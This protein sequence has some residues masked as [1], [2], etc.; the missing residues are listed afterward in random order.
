MD[1]IVLK[2]LKYFLG[3]FMFIH[4]AG[5]MVALQAFLQRNNP[6]SMFNRPE[7]VQPGVPAILMD[8]GPFVQV[9]QQGSTVLGSDRR[10]WLQSID[11]KASC[12]CLLAGLHSTVVSAD[13]NQGAWDW[14]QD[15]GRLAPLLQYTYA[16]LRSSSGYLATGWGIS[17]PA[18]L[19]ELW[20]ML[21]VEF[22]SRVNRKQ[23]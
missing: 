18:S 4:T 22:V 10:P 12:G 13:G 11:R 17:P 15:L 20:L 5:C 14:V 21:M 1:S 6:E 7:L 9:R 2:M 8:R 19:E 16:L 23:R 3:I